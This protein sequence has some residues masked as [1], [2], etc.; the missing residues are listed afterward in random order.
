MANNNKQQELKHI[1]ETSSQFVHDITTPLTN[2]QLS[3]KILERYIALLIEANAQ[4]S[5]SD[6]PFILTEQQLEQLV[7]LPGQIAELAQEVK[8]Q[9]KE[10][11]REIERM[12]TALTA[13]ESVS[14]IETSIGLA[15]NEQALRILVVEDDPIHQKIAERVLVKYHHIDIVNNGQEAITA[16][17]QQ[18][19]DVIL[20]DLYMPVLSGKDTLIQLQELSIALPLIIGFTNKP[21]GHEKQEL[22]RLGFAG[23]IEKPFSLSEFENLIRS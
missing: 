15:N 16:I 1:G 8:D 22:L 12:T 23:F 7:V 5:Q 11:W 13:D 4:H 10:Y 3:T 21:L 17:R 19:Y 18:Q 9:S 6:S 20:L 14:N 2:I